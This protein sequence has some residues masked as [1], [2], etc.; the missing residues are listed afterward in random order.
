MHEQ[1]TKREAE[2]DSRR[3][4]PDRSSQRRE[5]QTR[6]EDL[7]MKQEFEPARDVESKLRKK[8]SL[9][10]RQVSESKSLIDSLRTRLEDVQREKESERRNYE[11]DLKL[12]EYSIGKAGEE[13]LLLKNRI[14]EMTEKSDSA[15]REKQISRQLANERKKS[16][17]LKNMVHKLNLYIKDLSAYNQLLIALKEIDVSETIFE[18]EFLIRQ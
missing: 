5:S 16:A 7:L 6:L 8:L 10:E 18:K 9:S 11:A 4:E 17:E 15:E 1:N 3:K 12:K 2:L 13:I 14:K